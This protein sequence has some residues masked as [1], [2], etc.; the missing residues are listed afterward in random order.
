M[1]C[2]KWGDTRGARPTLAQAII[3][4]RRD[5]I[6][7]AILRRPMVASGRDFR[8]AGLP[9]GKGSAPDAQPSFNLAPDPATH[10]GVLIRAGLMVSCWIQCLPGFL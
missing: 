9:I 2:S 6:T 1:S 4:P 8:S 7:P 10:S 5:V 3:I